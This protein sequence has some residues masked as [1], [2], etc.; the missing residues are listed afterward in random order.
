MAHR[1]EFCNG[2]EGNGKIHIGRFGNRTCGG[3]RND[4]NS[5]PLGGVVDSEGEHITPGGLLWHVP[6]KGKK[7]FH[8]ELC[9]KAFQGGRGVGATPR[10]KMPVGHEFET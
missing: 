4:G 8:S 1:R 2:D 10:T 5:D 6:E 9:P 3:G 7:R